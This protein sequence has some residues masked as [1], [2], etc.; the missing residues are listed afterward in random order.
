MV[1]IWLAGITD[2]ILVG[3]RLVLIRRGWAIIIIV[4]NPIGVSISLTR[5]AYVIVI[6]IRLI[7]IGDINAVSAVPDPAV[8]I[9]NR[10]D[11][12]NSKLCTFI[13]LFATRI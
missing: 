2:T 5:I 7:R 13:L 10:R 11:R 9:G 3:I 6:G 12:L 4:D 8:G 1:R